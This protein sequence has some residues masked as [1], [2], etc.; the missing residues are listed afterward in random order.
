MPTMCVGLNC[1]ISLLLFTFEFAGQHADFMHCVHASRYSSMWCCTT[2]SLVYDS[3]DSK[4][5]PLLLRRKSI[6]ANN[7]LQSMPGAAGRWAEGEES[8]VGLASSL[9]REA[10][11]VFVGGKQFG[12]SLGGIARDLAVLV[13]PSDHTAFSCLLCFLSSKRLQGDK[14]MVEQ[15]AV[16]AALVFCGVLAARSVKI[17]MIFA[18]CASNALLPAVKHTLYPTHPH[19]TPKWMG[20][21]KASQQHLKQ[22]S[23][24]AVQ[25]WSGM[26][27]GTNTQPLCGPWCRCWKHAF[28]RPILLVTAAAANTALAAGE[29]EL[30]LA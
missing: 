18:F 19:T 1:F 29:Q 2:W 30:I 26:F 4:A 11:S 6:G 23:T 12:L 24:T 9:A 22:P 10:R 5:R 21:K 3:V 8:E 7:S 16:R 27:P 25:A 15:K 13:I 20:K 28:V 17:P 14:A